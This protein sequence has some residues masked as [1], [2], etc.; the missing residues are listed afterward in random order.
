MKLRTRSWD[1]A[2]RLLLLPVAVLFCLATASSAG[3]V[4]FSSFDFPGSTLTEAGAIT[5]SG[6]IVGTYLTPYTHMH[7][8]MVKDGEF[9]AVDVP[10]ATSTA[11][12]RVNAG[13]DIV[14]SY[15]DAR[16]GHGYVLRGGTFTTFDFSI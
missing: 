13:G 1:L 11:A 2:S 3:K 7:G 15:G 5:P 4:G 8:F 6:K 16:G 14:E 10:G 9:T 12:G